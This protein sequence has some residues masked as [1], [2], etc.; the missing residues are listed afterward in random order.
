MKKYIVDYITRGM[1]FQR[2][3]VEDMHPTGL[4]QPLPIQEMEMVSGNN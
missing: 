3:K 1:E 2:V 4:L